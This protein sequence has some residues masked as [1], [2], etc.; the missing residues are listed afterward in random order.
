[1]TDGD[2][3]F[4]LWSFYIGIFKKCQQHDYIFI[5]VVF[6]SHSLLLV[7]II[8]CYLLFLTVQSTDNCIGCLTMDLVNG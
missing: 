3:F 4:K 8:T 7:V 5:N 2:N 6:L 1:M